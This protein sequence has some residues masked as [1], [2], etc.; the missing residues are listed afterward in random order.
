MPSSIAGNT[1]TLRWT[2]PRA[3]SRRRT[4]CSKA[5]SIP[6]RCWPA[7]PSEARI[8]STPSSR[9]PVPSMSACTQCRAPPAV[10]ASNEIRI[11][12]NV[13]AAPSA[14]ADLLGLVNGSSVALAWRNTF[15][16]GAPGGLILDVTGRAHHL[17]CAWPDRQFPLRWR[18]RR[19]LHAGSSSRECRGQ[20]PPVERRHTDVSAAVFRSPSTA[21]QVPGVPDR[22]HHLRD[23][24]PGDQRIGAHLLCAERHG[25]VR[26]HL[27]HA[28]AR[29]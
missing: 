5:A 25:S 22:Q 17:D 16:G 20:Q 4:M 15:E 28:G 26:G 23:L 3:A 13:P 1:V 2:P 6:A 29:R 9:Q 19:H 7:S 8:P 24:G 12:V 21:C 10:D 14:P 18:P 27:C 11:F